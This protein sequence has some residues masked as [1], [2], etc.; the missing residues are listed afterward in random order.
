[1]EPSTQAGADAREEIEEFLHHTLPHKPF[2]QYIDDTVFLDVKELLTRHPDRQIRQWSENPRLYT[3]LRMLEY[4]DDGQIFKKFDSEQISDFWLP[5]TSASLSQ[6]AQTT[7]LNPTLFR[8]AQMHVLSKP[9]QM[10]DEK[11]TAASHVH[12]YIREGS[13]YFEEVDKIGRG[14]SAEVVRVRHKLSGK[15]FACKRILRADTVKAQKNQLIEFEQEVG[16]LQRLSHHHF[17]TFVASFTDLTSFSL[18]LNPVAK[19]VLKSMLERQA[20]DQPLPNED[21]STLRRSFGCLTTALTFLHEQKV[22]HK[23]IKPGNIL[24]SDGRIY[25]CDFGIARDWSKSEHSTTEGDVLKFTR[26]YCAPEVFGRDPRN[27]KSDIWSLGCVFLEIISV[28]KGYPLEEV[29]HFLLQHSVGASAQGLWCAPEAIQAWLV[30]I[31]SERHDSADDL[32]LD[33]II[34]M[35]RS[36]PDDRLKASQVLDMIH[37]QTNDIRRPDLFVASCCRRSDSLLP[38]DATTSTLS[39]QKSSAKSDSTSLSDRYSLDRPQPEGLGLQGVPASPPASY[40]VLP[41]RNK[42]STSTLANRG[43]SRERSVSPGTQSPHLSS[44]SSNTIPFS[45][46][47][48][49]PPP[50]AKF[51]PPHIAMRTY[52][53]RGSTHSAAKPSELISPRPT[54]FS[55]SGARDSLDF[56]RPDPDPPAMYSVKCGCAAQ[57]NEKHI[58]NSPLVSSSIQEDLPTI[59]TSPVCELREN[60]VQVYETLP[61]DPTAAN[62][63][64]PQIW[65][66]T[67]R[68]VISYL[69]GSPEIRRCSSFWIPLADIRFSCD[70]SDVTLQWSDCN[71]MTERRTAN[72]G[73]LYDWSYK[74][75]SPN[76]SIILRFQDAQQAYAFIDTVRLPY[77]DGV[78]IRTR[79]KVDISEMQEL[80]TFDLGRQG[81]QE[82]R[83]AV[84]TTV[85]DSFADS[86]LFIQ[87]P[88]VDLDIR[89]HD[90]HDQYVHAYQMVVRF[91]NVATPTYHSDIRGEPAVDYSRTASFSAARQ[92]KTSF[93]ATFPLGTRHSL[94]VPPVG[95]VNMLY[96]MTGWTLRYFAILDKFKSKNKHFWSKKYGRADILLFEKEVDDNSIRRR[97]TQLVVR[98]HEEIDFLWTAGSITSS[99]ALSYSSCEVTLTVS[100]KT[101]GR[102]LNVTN[103]TAVASEG[104]TK[105]QH[106]HHRSTSDAHEELSELVLTFQEERYRLEFDRIVSEFKAAAL[107]SAPLTRTATLAGSM[108]RFNSVTSNDMHPSPPM[109]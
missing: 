30:K 45:I 78:K 104:P 9:D 54:A 18:I 24:L 47:P 84:L 43:R 65:W 91:N 19:D 8:R 79:R 20:R 58:F 11:L 99:T 14:G 39:R 73:I 12:K 7:D 80:H 74:P 97:G 61:E 108:R 106:S 4:E 102:L 21:I 22:R 48:V 10:S 69:S 42:S 103:M 92:L 98:L 72:Y 95:M 31:R 1:M 41:T 59:Q 55:G 64:L 26:R 2:D 17:V 6:F 68:L 37:R 15:Q 56:Q 93:A 57:M 66:L 105:P 83:A 28:I 94:P 71:Q 52:S 36:E 70:G 35:I 44:E 51:T 85:Q 81:I 50:I 40:L 3:L 34:P 76:N 29:N 109:R 33:W 5:M 63:S 101:R 67:R 100:N 90:D 23:D 32:P 49:S 75:K 27:S 53:L 88:E 16:V 60:R 86:K 38:I 82:Y 87:W 13:A 77:E 46:E 62:I 107:A 89:V 96:N 25:L